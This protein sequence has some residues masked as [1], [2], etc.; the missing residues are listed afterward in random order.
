M[1]DSARNELKRITVLFSDMSG[2]TALSE[3]LHPEDVGE[4]ITPI[5]AGVSRIIGAHGGRV[6]KFI[7]DEVMAL[8]GTPSAREDDA[9]QAI[10][11]ALEI[12][13]FVDT[14]APRFSELIGRTICMHTGINTGLVLAAREYTERGTEEVLGD[15]VNLAARL[16]SLADSG[17]VV[18]GEDTYRV[19]EADFEF[20]ALPLAALKGKERAVQAYRVIRPKERP[21]LVH[22]LTGLRSRLVGREPELEVLKEAVARLKTGAGGAIC[23]IGD[24]GTGKS[25]LV[26]ELRESLDGTVGWLEGRNYG[27]S[28][29]V[30]YFTFINLLARAWAITDGEAPESVGAKIHEGLRNLTDREAVECFVRA[31]FGLDC[32]E[33]GE[34]EPQR[35]KTETEQGLI[36]ILASFARANATVV[37]LEDLHWADPSSLE[38]LRRLLAEEGPPLL[39]LFTARPDPAIE[40]G[41]LAAGRVHRVLLPELT[42]EQSREMLVSLLGN[43]DLPELLP[44]VLLERTEGN[45]F[46]LEEVVNYL[47][48]Q[49]VLVKQADR[50]ALARPV[51]PADVPTTVQAVVSARVDGLAPEAK[52]VLQRASVI[53]RRFSLRVLTAVAEDAQRLGST[54]GELEQH[55]LIRECATEPDIEYSFKHAVTQ[56]VVYEGV[57]R[58]E[59]KAVHERVGR[60]VERLFPDRTEDL[61]EYLAF[62]FQ[63]GESTH[64]AIGYLVR[65]GEKALSQYALEESERHFGEAFA[66]LDGR[67]RTREEDELLVDLVNRYAYLYFYRGDNAGLQRL[68]ESQLDLAACLED[69]A[70]HGWLHSWLGFALWGRGQLRESYDSLHQALAIGEEVGDARLVGYATARLAWTAAD[71]G[72]MAEAVAHAERALKLSAS[73]ESDRDLHAFARQGAGWVGFYT[74]RADFLVTTGEDLLAYGQRY[75]HNRSMSVGYFNLGAWGIADGDNASASGYFEEAAALSLDPV[76][77]LYNR[78]FLG[79]SYALDNRFEDAE[80]ALEGTLDE[81]E[82]SGYEFI[83]DYV[84]PFLGTALVA[85]GRMAEGIRMIEEGRANLLRA[86]AVVHYGLAGILMASIYQ[87]LAGGSERPGLSVIMSNIRFLARNIMVAGRKSEAHFRDAI[88][89]LDKAAATNYTAWARLGLGKLLAEQRRPE[90]AREVLLEAIALYETCDIKADRAAAQELLGRVETAAATD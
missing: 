73:M 75:S 54:L 45:P 20:E 66:L 57:L 40:A 39:F 59:R 47:I 70:G 7:G 61:V 76:Y 72:L 9:A 62:H 38:L 19:T 36:D 17:E 56:E 42:H 23:I 31:L 13:A 80:R 43:E 6:D 88:G 77:S 48:E 41:I 24:A 14:L 83:A 52:S 26:A 49:N 29:D 16:T 50:W 65:A 27:R 18:V 25:R 5:M 30:A 53:G 71:L 85:N 84:R 28:Q 67:E 44:P 60:A 64:K 69:R 68:V 8:F 12:H 3:N 22:R 11:A 90:E 35:R 81:C 82:R 79:A 33:L 58:A 15:A 63:R 87:E 4:I 10:R 78:V 34:V 46:Y 2:Y 89:V 32:P 1:Q 86:G 37:H 51:D 74:G 21:T 55:D